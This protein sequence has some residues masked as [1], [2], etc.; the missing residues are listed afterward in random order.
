MDAQPGTAFA[1]GNGRQHGIGGMFEPRA[2]RPAG[3]LPP[4]GGEGT[5]VEVDETFIGHDLLNPPMPKAKVGIH[6]MNKVLSL[7]NRATG[8]ARSFVK[9]L[10]MATIVPIMEA[11]IPARVAFRQY[12][13]KLMGTRNEHPW[14]EPVNTMMYCRNP[15]GFKAPI[16]TTRAATISRVASRD[17]MRKAR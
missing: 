1:E 8:E 16:M 6:N 14:P 10:R 2:L 15:G 4:M 9:D 17:R 3:D 7:V 11:N 12:K 5:V 13:L